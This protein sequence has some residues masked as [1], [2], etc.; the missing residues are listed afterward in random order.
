MEE[1]K[2]YRFVLFVV[3]ILLVAL[4][5][6]KPERASATPTDV[7]EDNAFFPTATP[8]AFTEEPPIQSPGMERQTAPFQAMQG[9]TSD[10]ESIWP[11]FNISDTDT[12]SIDPGI[13]VDSAGRIHMVWA[14]AEEGTK[15][16]IYYA[17]WD[18]VRLSQTVSA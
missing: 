9:A 1:K 15:W 12:A 8:T 17:Y 4:A 7:I 18:G 14:E 13:A 11:A 10:L 6:N 3:I 5:T 2:G 16:E